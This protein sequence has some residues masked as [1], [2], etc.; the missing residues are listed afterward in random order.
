MPRTPRER[1]V[2]KKP[3]L[4]EKTYSVGIYARLS[5]DSHSEK[6]E[7]IENQIEIA[8]QYLNNQTDM[9][10]YDCYSDLGKSGTNFCR[11]NFERLMQDVRRHRVD[12]I[13]VKDF[14]RFGRNY[15]E[16]G[17]YLEKIFPFLGVRFVSVADGFDTLKNDGNRDF[18]GVNLKNLVN[19]LYA[20][21]IAVKVRASRQIQRERGSYT[22]GIAP[23]GYEARWMNG[24]K[25]LFIER[26]TAG[27]VKRLFELY[28]DGKSQK[29]LV[30]WLYERKI[31]RPN[32]Y[33]RTGHIYQR[34][35]E[36]LQQWDRGSLKGVLQ[37]PVYLGCLVQ[38]N[39]CGGDKKKEKYKISREDWSVKE[40]THEAVV[41]DE[42][43]FTVAER[44][45]KQSAKCMQ[46]R[47]DRSVPMEEDKMKG[48]LFCGECKKAMLRTSCVKEFSSHDKVRLYAYNCVNIRKIDGMNCEK[49]YISQARLEK[50]VKESLRKEFLLAGVVPGR[51]V[52]ER[53]R[54]WEQEK[55]ELLTYK[56]Q[57]ER[58]EKECERQASEKYLQYREG[59]ISQEDFLRWQEEGRLRTKKWRE[60][61]TRCDRLLKERESEAERQC[62]FLRALLKFD[63]TEELDRELLKLL[64]GRIEVYP[65]KRIEIT[66]HF[67]AVELLSEEMR[68]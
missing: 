66:F 15:V 68:S 53:R 6:N 45:E 12:C 14:S 8:K 55:Q 1:T 32:D 64:I 26:E 63:E 36:I 48:L 40:C 2:R 50:I 56:K 46:N 3:A 65:K 44:F 57:L 11:E 27:I 38:G 33:R 25:Q 59:R 5:V 58:E 35:H 42:L 60:E 34:E 13:I 20:K 23:Y 29:D 16:M 62:R 10:L 21:D 47:L 9:V 51:L 4:S 49:K 22:G 24:K 17:N 19:E 7:S 30:T 67:T 41:S 52:K 61:R 28:G 39:T 43:F 18:L 54:I 31:H 37:N